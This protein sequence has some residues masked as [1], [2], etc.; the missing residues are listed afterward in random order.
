MSIKKDLIKFTPR[1]E[2]EAALDYI[3]NVCEKKPDNKFFLLNMPVGIGKSHL[4]IMISDY[5]TTAVIPGGKVDIVTAGKLLQDQYEDTYDE[6]KSF[7]GKDNYNCNQY[8]TSCHNGSEFNKLNKTKCDF[9]PYELA[10]DAYLGCQVGL[11]NF[12]LYLIHNIYEIGGRDSKILIIDEAHLFDDVI[13]NFISIKV[14][15]TQIK[16]FHLTN[17]E[18]ILKKLDRVVSIETYIEFLAEL[19][20]EFMDIVVEINQFLGDSRS[21][22]KN[23]SKTDKRELKISSITG[24]EYE[25]VKFIKLINE[26]IQFSSKLEFFLKEYKE[27]ESNWILERYFNEKTNK[28]ELSL[29]PIWVDK[30]LEKFIW[31][32]Y[33][34]IFLMSGTILNKSLFSKIAGID[35]EKTVYYSANSPF[36]LSKRKIFYLPLGKMSFTKKE[37]TF[38]NFIPFFEKLVKKYSDVKGIIH[39]NSFELANWIKRDFKNKR[40]IFHDSEDKEQK[41][42]QHFESSEPTIIVSPSVSTGV[43]FDHEKSRFQV[44]AKVPYP[45]LAS[46]RN[47]VRQ[48]MNPEWYSWKTVCD[49][50]QACGRSVRSYTDYA[51]TIIIDSSFGDVLRYSSHHFP[52]WFIDSIKTIKN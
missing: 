52:N 19:S 31:S 33:E 18:E 48:K 16:K 21:G 40:F 20:T 30:Y 17:E 29:E 5:I 10:K 39:T 35:V 3:K 37:E 27:D 34:K 32:K 50:I 49:I 26:I 43:S 47:K 24:I 15:E 51:D 1:K 11:T 8:E 36:E 44:L 2:Q 23:S 38:N 4:A 41:L 7:R 13:T 14:T 12:H 42:R 46:Q 28:Y 9:C 22:M 25:D 6:V 45:S